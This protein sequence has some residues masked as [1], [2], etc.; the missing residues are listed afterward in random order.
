MEMQGVCHKKRDGSFLAVK[1][2]EAAGRAIGGHESKNE[3][4]A[5]RTT[6]TH[7]KRQ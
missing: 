1:R 6:K 4:L 3:F 2:I 7:W 5:A